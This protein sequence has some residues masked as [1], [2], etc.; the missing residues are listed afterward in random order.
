MSD[1][2]VRNKVFS[3]L[4]R[5]SC[6]KQDVYENTVQWF[7]ILKEVLSEVADELNKD[8]LV[9]GD[10]RIQIEFIDKGNFEAQFRMAGDLLI[11]HMHTNVFMFDQSHFVWKSPYVKDEPLHAYCGE[12]NIYNF[13]NDS[14]KFNRM[15]DI[16]YMIARLFI[17]A[18]NHFIV[19]GRRQFGFRYNDFVNDELEREQLKEIVYTC[20]QYAIDFDLY[21]PPYEAVKESTVYEMQALSD[22]LRLRTGK[23]L[24]FKFESE[25]DTH[26][27]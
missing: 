20:L 13:L 7:S 19:D 10:K 18:E 21:T 6:H 15:N 9:C 24:G 1:E 3:E 26:I 16:G 22:H 2:S 11:F 17:N 23:R 8:M 25:T 12:I 14:F 4:A 27:S 5:K